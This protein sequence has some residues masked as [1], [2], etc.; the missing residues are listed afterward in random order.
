MNGEISDGRR[1]AEARRTKAFERVRTMD[2][3]R[4]VDLETELKVPHGTAQ[5]YLTQWQREGLVDYVRKE[6]QVRFYIS[7][8]RRQQL[9]EASAKVAPNAAGTPEGNMWRAMRI[10]RHFTPLDIAAHSN[11]GGVQVSVDKARSYCRTLLEGGYLRIRDQPIRGRRE[12]LF[13][14]VRNTGPEA[15]VT[16]RVTVLEDSNI[17]EIS[18][19]GRKDAP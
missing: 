1:T 15:P 6:G 13:Q 12:A 18:V 8:E 17:G 11:A 4:L 19:V 16:R 5:R 2:E 9:I 3:F 10:L 14:L 7:A